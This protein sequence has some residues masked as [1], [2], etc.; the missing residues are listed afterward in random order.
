MLPVKAGLVP[1]D[2]AGNLYCQMIAV[3]WELFDL[4]RA[5]EWTAATERCCETFDSA[6]MFSGIC[7][8]HRVQLRQVSGEWDGAADDARIVCTELAGL[9]TQVVAEGHYLLGELLRLRND[10]VGAE[11]AY[12][13]AH[14]LGRD[15]QPGLALLTAQ[16]DAVGAGLASLRAALATH[17]G[18][19]YSRAPLLHAVVELAVEVH[20]LEVAVEA[21][22]QL[23]AIAHR[24]QSE[25]LYVVAA[26]ARGAVQ[27]ATG[28]PAEA[29]TGLREAI[30]C[31]QELGAPY[32]CARSRMLLGQA[33]SALGDRGAATRE[34]DVAERTLN[35]LAAVVDLRRLQRLRPRALPGG[36]TLREAE[37]LRQVTFG[38]THKQVADVL[39]ISEK[40]VARHLAN[41]YVKLGV[42]TRTAAVA[43]ARKGGL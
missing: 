21:S 6:V 34:L 13:R 17:Q 42:S 24:W 38:G 5:R 30:R 36:L 2:M 15:P 43:W 1:P 8:M 33:Y 18:A 29:V 10:V 35:A 3:C 32:A 9:N 39:V 20:E 22:E 31:W 37:I 16:T 14:E 12:L 27:V 19:E 40:T 41:I 11:A 28:S 23:T 26:Q 25:G 7:R 4:R